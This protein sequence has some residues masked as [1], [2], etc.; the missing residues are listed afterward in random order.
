LGNFFHVVFL[1]SS[2]FLQVSGESFNLRLSS[3]DSFL[4]LGQFLLICGFEFGFGWS[5]WLL[6]CFGLLIPFVG[7]FFSNLPSLKSQF[8]HKKKDTIFS[9]AIFDSVEFALLIGPRGITK[10]APSCFPIAKIMFMPVRSD[11][12]KKKEKTIR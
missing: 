6:F 10:S 12:P 4:D 5:W 1:F 8:L 7:S 3:L 11:T 2:K 9:K